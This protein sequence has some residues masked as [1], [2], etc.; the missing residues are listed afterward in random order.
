MSVITREEAPVFD[1]GGAQIIGLASPS[2]GSSTLAA[3]RVNLEADRPS[4]E[5]SLSGEEVF[6]VLA[7]SVTAR[8]A[9]REETAS[10]GGALIV[11]PGQPL[12]LV[13]RDAPAEAICMLRVGTQATVDGRSFTPPWAE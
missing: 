2:R 1:T 9:D 5:H 7:G 13:A 8:F 6:I 4:P 12:S 11:A 3:W 10:A